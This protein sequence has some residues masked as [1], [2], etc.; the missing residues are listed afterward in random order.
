MKNAT[1]LKSFR[2][3]LTRSNNGHSRRP[4]RRKPRMAVPAMEALENRQLLSATFSGDVGAEADSGSDQTVGEPSLSISLQAVGTDGYVGGGGGDG[5]DYA[6]AVAVDNDGNSFV[7][8]TVDATSRGP[9]LP[10]RVNRLGESDLFVASSTAAGELRWAYTLGGDGEDIATGVAIGPNGHVFVT[11]NFQGTVDFDPQNNTDG[12]GVRQST[13]TGQ[14]GFDFFVLELT[15]DGE[16]VNVSTFGHDSPVWDYA[17]DIAVD[18][19][20]GI[21]VT[22]WFGGRID[23]NPDPNAT[24]ILVDRGN[25]DVFLIRLNSTGELD[26]ARAIGGDRTGNFND[27]GTD[28]EVDADGNVFLAGRVFDTADFDRDI[29]RADGSDT[30]Q[31]ITD[32]DAFVASYN[33]DGDFRWVRR[34]GRNTGSTEFGANEIIHGLTVTPQGTVAA[35]GE[36]K[37]GQLDPGNGEAQLSSAGSGADVFITEF[38]AGDGTWLWSQTIGSQGDD[39]GRGIASDAD[40]NLYVT[41]FYNL[42]VDFDASD[43]SARRT[44]R[45]TGSTGA[46]DGFVV[47]FNSDREFEA[48]NTF[49]SELGDDVA[50]VAVDAAGRVHLAGYFQETA[51]FENGDASATLVSEGLRDAFLFVAP[52]LEAEE[53][54]ELVDVTVTVTDLDGDRLDEI[55][56]GQQFRIDVYAQDLRSIAQGVTALYADVQFDTSLVD[57]TDLEHTFGGFIS[58]QLNDAAGLVDE[59]GGTLFSLPA[60]PDGPQLVFSLLATATELGELTISTDVGEDDLSEN[61]LLGRLEDVRSRTRYGSL[62]VV[63]TGQPDLQVTTFNAVD[64]LLIGGRTLIEFAI[65][66]QG[67]APSGDF[68]V[69]II[70]SD[71]DIIG[72]DDDIVV[73]TV[74]VR[75]LDAGETRTV[76]VD[77]QLDLTILRDRAFRD[78]PV[79]QG[80]GFVSTSADLLG[81][82]IDP[83][84]TVAEQTETHGGQGQGIDRDDVTYFPFD[85]N[86]DGR[87]RPTDVN[88]VLSNLGAANSDNAA[89]DINGDGRV[90]LLDANILQ[91]RR[92]YRRNESVRDDVVAINPPSGSGQDQTVPVVIPG[93]VIVVPVFS[94]VAAPVTAESDAP[95]PRAQAATQPPVFNVELEQ[96]ALPFTESD[97]AETPARTSTV[98][99]S[100]TDLSG[101]DA[102]TFADAHD[103]G[104]TSSA[105]LGPD[106]PFNDVSVVARHSTSGSP[107]STPAENTGVADALFISSTDWIDS[108]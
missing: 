71:D 44:A 66:N 26:W 60:N 74:T 103:D 73:K 21:L 70:H 37:D 92:G 24:E 53:P 93:T 28:V 7:V 63:I 55:Q 51:T 61:T 8:G 94:A 33:K 107:D 99:E 31:A 64:D 4:A 3:T 22:G 27:Y 80:T 79:G 57:V 58:G 104:H 29:E 9:G 54:A 97:T 87:V 72:N 95:Q 38:D 10:P 41:G 34:V 102:A 45:D 81:L 49:G 50:A 88:Q 101:V 5:E 20:G 6:T 62:T 78:H 108:V 82:E 98:E 69:D 17:T 16:F 84:N 43:G 52:G 48:V 89:A 12:R 2:D 36:F 67:N 13:D 11:G 46:G 86:A 32:G 19:A 105:A 76:R 30:I 1:W 23:V 39:R 100:A 75:G 47:K 14:I 65:Y 106:V 42:T 91:N 15:G 35:V 25:Q 68:D 56:L 85:V 77:V 40:G 96:T 90:N 83:Q 59:A 18:S